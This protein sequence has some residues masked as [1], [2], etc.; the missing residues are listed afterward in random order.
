MRAAREALTGG[1]SPSRRDDSTAAEVDPAGGAQDAPGAARAPHGAMSDAFAD[2]ALPLPLKRPLTYAV[3]DELAGHLEPGWRVVVPVQQREMV[4][5]VTATGRP[6]PRVRAREIVT[7]P[8]AGPVLEPSLLALARHIGRYYAAPPG[9]ALRAMLPA[10]LFSVGRPVVTLAA[11][12]LPG[13]AS[14]PGPGAAGGAAEPVARLFRAPGRAVPLAAVRRAAGSAGLRYVRRLVAEGAAHVVTLPPRT[15]APERVER[16]FELVQRY[17]HLLEL[18]RRFAR[19]PKQR[20]A[21]ET[22]LGLGGSASAKALQLKGVSPVALAALVAR[23]EVRSGTTPALRDPFAALPASA[24]PAEPTGAQQ[25]AIATLARLPP[26]G[27]ALLFGVTGSGKTLVYLEYLRRLV[28]AGRGAIVLVPEIALTPQMVSRLRGVFGDDVAVLHS[29]LSDGERYDAWRELKEGRRHVAIGA[30]S[31]VFAPVPRLGAIVLDEEH[32]ASYKQGEAPRYHAREVA[33][34]RAALAGATVVLGSATPSLE[35]WA[36]AAAGAYRLIELPERVGARPLPPVDVVDLRTAPQRPDSGAVPWTEALDGAVQGALERGEQA[37]ILLNRRGFSVY[38]QCP[39]CG[40]VWACPNCSITL[41]FHRSPASLRCHHCGHRAPPPTLCSKCGS[42]TQRYRGVGTQQVEA[43]V[44]GRF[45][46]ARIARMDVDSTAGKWSH[47]RILER[48]GA[49]AVDVLVG[50]QMIAKGLDF[51]RVTVVGVVDADVALNLPDFRAAERTF[52]LLTQVAGRTGRGPLGGRVIVQ[53]RAPAHH[54]VVFAARHDVR[55]FMAAE[56]AERRAPAYPP[57]VE[58]ANVVVSG[59]D[60]RAVARGAVAVGEWLRALVAARAE[61][62]AAVLGPA[63]CPIERI[64]ERWRWHLLLKAGEPGP[65]T[66][67]VR[68]AAAR[69]PVPGTLRLVV[70]RDPVSLL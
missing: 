46:A 61:L 22:L 1:A 12:A 62:G 35:S 24:P 9:L 59:T 27:A 34:R 10:A 55:G 49:G 20:E 8:D 4:G 36:A 3:P 13:P 57:H 5:V 6:A 43:F 56:L 52:D 67:L 54:A 45:P 18:E 42:Q 69:A 60:E 44:A 17:E 19:S 30:R 29:G 68:Y 51:P 63:P 58:L 70:D 37:M 38:V 50:T 7:A 14:G 28:A 41:T 64:R 32:D 40:E 39:S 31:A 53:T 15:A 47:H 11:D 33:L 65:L 2:V 21:Y 66:R 23:G 48:V 16:T 25:E 26:G